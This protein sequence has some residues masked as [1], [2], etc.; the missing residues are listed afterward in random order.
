MLSFAFLF[1][2]I[3]LDSDKAA[4]VAAHMP[5]FGMAALV[6]KLAITPHFCPDLTPRVAPAFSLKGS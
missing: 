5:F 1:K 3:L 4:G 6:C 2:K